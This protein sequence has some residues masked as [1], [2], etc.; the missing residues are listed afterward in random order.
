MTRLGYIGLGNMGAPMAKRLLDRPGGLT[1][2][3]ARPEAVEPF[4]AAGARVAGD[5][6]DLARDCDVVCVTVVD[7]AQVR[8]VVAGLLDTARPGTVIA[9]HSTIA[10]TTAVELAAE[11]ADRGVELVD[12]PVS[13]GAPGAEQGRLAVMVG[14]SDAA[15]DAVREPFSRFADLVVHAGPVGA[16]T[17]MKLARNL[18][19]FVSFTAAAEAQ[20]LAEAAGLD[21]TA[22]GK[23]VRH[24][25]AITGGAGAIMLRDTT[26]PI[27][28]DDFW[29]P[30]L[31]H[32]RDLGEKDLSLAL[33]LGARLGVDLP[34]AT[35]ALTGLG[36]GLGVG[37]GDVESRNR[38]E[39]RI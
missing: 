2:L 31:D 10:D 19:H 13:G 17:R 35:R 36:P 39:E 6:A 14:A 12:A 8:T 16:G 7:D 33:G 5:P 32:V 25:D 30:I 11:C 24:T 23:V 29:F 9:V 26:A 15:F 38:Q 21:I 1:V 27:P 34:L 4:T 22:L 18:L 28:P 20:R 37:T 3:D